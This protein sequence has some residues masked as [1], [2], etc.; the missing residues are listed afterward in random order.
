MIGLIKIVLTNG[1]K[2]VAG[3]SLEGYSNEFMIDIREIIA[4]MKNRDKCKILS[5]V[6]SENCNVP[7]WK[8][9]DEFYDDFLKRYFAVL[10][11]GQS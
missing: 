3:E 4:V 1:Y 5:R 11:G 6:F 8:M 2:A 7:Q 10:R 9:I